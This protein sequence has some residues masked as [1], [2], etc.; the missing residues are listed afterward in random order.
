VH[1]HYYARS[2][3]R[4]TDDAA[5]VVADTFNAPAARLLQSGLAAFSCAVRTLLPPGGA[6]LMDQHVYYECATALLEYAN[7]TGARIFS[8][9]LRCETSISE[10]IAA[11]DGRI[12]VIVGDSPANWFLHHLPLAR[13]RQIADDL[14]AKLLLD[15]SV[16]PLQKAALAFADLV[17]VSLSKWPSAG[18]T[19]G[20]A[21]IGQRSM[22]D[23]VTRVA[24]VDGHAMSA[25]VAFTVLQQLPTLRDRIATAS[26]KAQL[27]APLLTA[28]PFVRSVR[29]ASGDELGNLIGGMVVLELE[30]ESTG[31]LLEQLIGYNS[32]C[33][34]LTLPQLA[35]TF[36]GVIS[37][38]E[39]FGS[40]VRQ[41]TGLAADRQR[42]GEARIPSNFVRLSIG[43]EEGEA[44]ADGLLKLLNLVRDRYLYVP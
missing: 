29:L 36:G 25:E 26:A 1:G 24:A 38:L 5:A 14:D 23:R 42:T 34:S 8:V 39:H 18:H 21:V 4:S 31:A 22:I 7:L 33:R 11:A 32:M 2:S 3:T 15:T 41:R 6:A 20:G 28:H 35:C 17:V 30:D 19:I 43:S 40:N 13:L 44:L 12:D 10:A 9:D 37:T 27:I 16:Q